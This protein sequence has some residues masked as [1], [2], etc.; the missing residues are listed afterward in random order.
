MACCCVSF[1]F[2]EKGV[3]RRWKALF[4]RAFY[5]DYPTRI[6]P[7][8][9]MGHTFAPRAKAAVLRSIAMDLNY[10]KWDKVVSKHAKEEVVV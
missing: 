4:I 8:V 10:A 1:S 3:R 9:P 6:C 2:F 5:S 7:S